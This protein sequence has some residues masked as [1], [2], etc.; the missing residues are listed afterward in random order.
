VHIKEEASSGVG[1]D[2]GDGGGGG[3]SNF[4]H[5]SVSYETNPGLLKYPTGLED[6]YLNIFDT[7]D[8]GISDFFDLG[9]G[10]EDDDAV[11]MSQGV[12]FGAP[13]ESQGGRGSGGGGDDEDRG[14]AW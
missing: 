11:N 4:H 12:L 8:S 10:H 3:D 5:I 9:G 14:L 1:G 13:N 6:Y 7:T 2:G